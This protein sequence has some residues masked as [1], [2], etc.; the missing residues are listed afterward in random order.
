[1]STDGLAQLRTWVALVVAGLVKEPTAISVEPV[2]KLG[3][4]RTLVLML[5]AAPEDVGRII[6]RAGALITPLRTLVAAA[7]ARRGLRVTL[8]LPDEIERR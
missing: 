7:G 1:M 8:E 6:G 2:G 5:R 4:R 3:G